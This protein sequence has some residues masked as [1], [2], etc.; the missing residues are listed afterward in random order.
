MENTIKVNTASMLLTYIALLWWRCR[1]IGKRQSEIGIWQEF[2]Y[3]LKGQFYLEFSKKKL[4][5]CCDG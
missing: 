3:E 4:D 2:Q 1:S 5:Q